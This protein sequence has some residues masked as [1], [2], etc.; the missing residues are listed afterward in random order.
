VT[1]VELRARAEQL[2]DRACDAADPRQADRLESEAAGLLQLADAMEARSALDVL[3]QV[4]PRLVAGQFD[5]VGERIA[6]LAAR[7]RAQ[8]SLRR[9]A[10]S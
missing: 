4:V 1:P 10:F 9:R 8:E 2:R 7:L 6:R 3:E 5:A